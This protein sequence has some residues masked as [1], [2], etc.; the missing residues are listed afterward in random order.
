MT[1]YYENHFKISLDGGDMGKCEI[2]GKPTSSHEVG[3]KVV[4]H[5]CWEENPEKIERLK[6]EESQRKESE[7]DKI[8]RSGERISEELSDVEGAEKVTS[9]LEDYQDNLDLANEKNA[10]DYVFSKII[11]DACE[12]LSDKIFEVAK[13]EGWSFLLDLIESHPPEKTPDSMPIV[14]AVS[15]YVI[16]TRWEKDVEELPVKA[17]KYL[18]NF[19]EGVDEMWE[20]SFTCGWGFDHPEFDFVGALESAIEKGQRFWAVG[21]LEQV[22][23]FDQES[24]AEILIN[25]LESEDLTQDEKYDLVQSVALLGHKKWDTTEF[26]PHFWDWKQVLGYDGFEW[27]EEVESDLREVIEKELDDHVSKVVGE[28]DFHDLVR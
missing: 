9:L 5:P 24:G 16:L 7:M 6:E 8:K 13:K 12:P 27:D 15:R 2:C 20:D 3:E 11:D 14:N 28:W 26:V 17:L 18:T 22:F 10:R 1:K 19:D 23:Y 4:C 21:A 25:F